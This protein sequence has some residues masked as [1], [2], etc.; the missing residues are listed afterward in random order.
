VHHSFRG[1]APSA[2]RAHV[3]TGCCGP[4]ARFGH[5]ER[6]F[7]SDDPGAFGVRRPLRFLAH[8][9]NLAEPQ[10]AELARILNE[11]KTERAQAAVDDRRSLTAFADALSGEAFDAP[12]A[13]EAARVR[14]ESARRL[15]RRCSAR[16]SRSTRC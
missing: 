1:F 10:I 16:W 5:W 14:S 8:R 7:Y 9:L 4:A 2:H 15:E 13:A 6:H 11:L 3:E 12:R